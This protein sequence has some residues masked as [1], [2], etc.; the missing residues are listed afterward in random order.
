M[1]ITDA[2][3]YLGGRG[4]RKTAAITM[5]GF[6]PTVLLPEES[7]NRCQLCVVYWIDD[8]QFMA[9]LL[10]KRSPESVLAFIQEH[11]TEELAFAGHLAPHERFADQS[12]RS[13]IPF[14]G[15]LTT[16]DLLP[17]VAP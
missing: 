2:G 6:R 3:H 13:V 15:V 11:G 17:G 12:G 10:L 5:V 4:L 1:S 14:T 16:I 7:P 8:T 9:S